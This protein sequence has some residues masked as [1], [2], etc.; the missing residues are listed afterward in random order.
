MVFFR[1]YER[2][3]SVNIGRVV[4]YIRGCFVG[5]CGCFVGY[6]GCFVGYCGIECIEC[7]EVPDVGSQGE[8][9]LTQ[10]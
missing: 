1:S 4:E 6:C 2:N 10:H 7:I 3:A 9:A 8:T 5:Y